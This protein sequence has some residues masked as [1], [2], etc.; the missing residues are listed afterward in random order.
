MGVNP[1]VVSIIRHLLANRTC[2]VRYSGHYSNSYNM[3][4][5][6]PQGGV[7]SPLLFNLYLFDIPERNK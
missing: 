6:V 7:I 4:A 1:I 3:P 2:T 5:G